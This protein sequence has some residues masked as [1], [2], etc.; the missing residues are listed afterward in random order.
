MRLC[1]SLFLANTLFSVY[2]L[3][4]VKI[5][6]SILNSI[7]PFGFPSAV[8]LFLQVQLLR[9][10]CTTIFRVCSSG[11]HSLNPTLILCHPLR[12]NFP[13]KR[14]SCLYVRRD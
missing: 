4:L 10:L 3:C 1:V 13:L 8:Q 9:G 6:L 2:S 5:K 11:C 7:T 14:N 12:A